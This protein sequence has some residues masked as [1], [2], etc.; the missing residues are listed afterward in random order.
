MDADR[1]LINTTIVA[2]YNGYI[3]HISL[4]E[5]KLISEYSEG[6]PVIAEFLN[7]D[8]ITLSAGLSSK[9]SMQFKNA[10]LARVNLGND[11]YREATITFISRHTSSDNPSFLIEAKMDNSDLALISGQLVDMG[12]I[13]GKTS[14]H[15]VPRQALSIDAN[16]AIALKAVNT[17]NGLVQSF[18][19]PTIIDQD[20]NF[21]WVSG[22]PEEVNL[23]TKGH[24]YLMEGEKIS[25]FK[26]KSSS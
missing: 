20:S 7:L 2:P 15:K 18:K 9:E 4:V 12:I 11:S 25:S 22:L 1:N 10:N 14:A 26:N 23:L 24:G 3:D 13:L 21:I 5:G 17:S 16:G 8:T 19:N 6:G